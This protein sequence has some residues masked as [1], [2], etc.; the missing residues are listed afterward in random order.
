MPL[1]GGGGDAKGLGKLVKKEKSDRKTDS[2][3]LGKWREW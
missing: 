2:G 1:G 3:K